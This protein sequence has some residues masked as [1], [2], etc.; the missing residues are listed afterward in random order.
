MEKMSNSDPPRK[1]H[2]T[3]VPKTDA[4]LIRQIKSIVNTGQNVEIKLGTDGNLKVFTVSKR[5]ALIS[6]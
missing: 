6:K 2:M 5:I 1:P 3:V 4:N